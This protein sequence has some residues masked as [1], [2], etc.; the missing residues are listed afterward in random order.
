MRRINK[1]GFTLIELIVV[2]VILA[3]LALIVTPIVLNIIDKAK[4]SAN[5]RSVDGYGKAMELAMQSYKL[6]HGKFT[7]DVNELNIDYSENNITCDEI[8]LNENGSVF[9]S[10]CKID[11]EYIEDSKT[12]D[13]YYQYGE[14][15]PDYAIGDI[16]TYSNIKFYVINNSNT[17]IDYVTLLK[18]EPLTVDEVNTYG[19][20]HV[21]MYLPPS[22]DYSQTA[23]NR[24][25]YGGMAYYSRETCGY[26]NNDYVA[27][28]CITEYDQSDIKYV[29][30]NWSNSIIVNGDDLVI[31]SLGYKARL[32][33]TT[34]LI[35]NL[36]FT[37]S[38]N[39]CASS[40][41]PEWEKNIKVDYWTMDETTKENLLVSTTNT[42][43]IIWIAG[44]G[45]LNIGNVMYDSYTVRP[46]INLKKSAIE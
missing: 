28:E 30:D 17:A 39:R 41:T 16:V 35:K 32:I 10:K 4:D 40:E 12:S 27:T 8:V 19:V 46:V 5:K 24:N 34:E 15:I 42:G 43:P 38:V 6:E 37:N 29:V 7:Y 33:T 2:L 1:Q 3:I 23:R 20:G 36:K 25:G 31:D 26:P 22:W 9:I 14:I 44:Y 45:C 18:A 11:G 21:N 13:G